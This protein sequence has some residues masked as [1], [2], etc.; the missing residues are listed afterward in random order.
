MYYIIIP[1]EEIPSKKR[2]PKPKNGDDMI[3]LYL[4][5][6]MI[7]EEGDQGDQEEDQREGE[8]QYFRY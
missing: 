2:G 8:D 6:Q 5:P 1:R 4:E 7:S 3:Y